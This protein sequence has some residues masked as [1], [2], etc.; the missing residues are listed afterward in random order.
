[1]AQAAQCVGN[2]GSAST[3]FLPHLRREEGHIE[4]M[5]LLGK[6]VVFKAAF[7]HHDGVK[8]NGA[9][10]LD[11]HKGFLCI[12]VKKRGFRYRPSRRADPKRQGGQGVR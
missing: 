8:G 12:G 2:V 6:D 10:D 5:R 9:A 3:V 1:M 11:R 4:H 7:K